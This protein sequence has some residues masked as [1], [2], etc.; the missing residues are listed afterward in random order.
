MEPAGSETRQ[1]ELPVTRDTTQIEIK[2]APEQFGGSRLKSTHRLETR[3]VCHREDVHRRSS[4]TKTA[5]ASKSSTCVTG[6]RSM[7]CKLVCCCGCELDLFCAAVS[8]GF[9]DNES[10]LGHRFMKTPR[11]DHWPAHIVPAVNKYRWDAIEL[12]ETIEDAPV[13]LQ[14][15]LI[16]P[17]VRY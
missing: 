17:V 1:S 3:E 11:C 4:R 12:C 7:G 14:E 2:P 8:F 5:V 10:A 13:A 15:A 16:R 9:D 6:E